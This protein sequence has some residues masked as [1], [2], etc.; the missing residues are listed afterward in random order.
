[1]TIFICFFHTFLDLSEGRI[2]HRPMSLNTTTA[3]TTMTEIYNRN[4]ITMNDVS[5]FLQSTNSVESTPVEDEPEDLLK[6]ID[7]WNQK[8]SGVIFFAFS[9]G[10][11]NSLDQH[12]SVSLIGLVS[13]GLMIDLFWLEFLNLPFEEIGLIETDR[14]SSTMSTCID[15]INC[16]A[17]AVFKSLETFLAVCMWLTMTVVALLLLLN[18]VEW[19][20]TRDG[21]S[22]V[23]LHSSKLRLFQSRQQQQYRY[24]Q[25]LLSTRS[26]ADNADAA[27]KYLINDDLNSNYDDDNIDNDDDYY[28]NNNNNDKETL[29]CQQAK[30]FITE[31]FQ[32]LWNNIKA[33]W[34]AN[35]L[36]ITDLLPNDL[37]YNE[38]LILAC[39]CS[40][41][42]TIGKS[43]SDFEICENR[44]LHFNKLFPYT[45]MKS[46]DL[47]Y[48]KCIF[49]H[50][51]I[52]CRVC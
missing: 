50:R 35:R 37:M 11:S 24:V 8:V 18:I 32:Q 2:Q 48:C 23:W 9:C 15:T 52:V 3:T 10:T 13:V 16:Q 40:I 7:K 42:A 19:I 46:L 20:W 28:N 12:A 43:V 31:P 38:R 5:R 34:R 30:R 39:V 51:S 25:S 47:D 6:F 21:S 45:Y 17:T 1:M 29:F 26:N 49:I 22:N 4:E 41:L 36:Y 27:P 33:G 14:S 44:F